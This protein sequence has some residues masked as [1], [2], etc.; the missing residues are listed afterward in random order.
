[1]GNI[2]FDFAQAND[3]E[4]LRVGTARATPFAHPSI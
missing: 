4:H 3:D 1:V 2:A